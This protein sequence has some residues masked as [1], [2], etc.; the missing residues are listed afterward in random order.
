[1]RHILAATAVCLLVVVVAE[2]LAA[3]GDVTTVRITDDVAVEDTMRLGINTCGDNYWDSSIVKVRAAQNFEGL[4]YRFMSWGP[5]QDENGIFVW[6]APAEEAW[7]AMKGRV[8]WHLLGGPGKGM[9]GLIKDI[10]RKVCPADHQ[11]RELCYISFDKP[12]PASDLGKNGIMLELENFGQG[13]IRQTNNPDFWNAKQNTAQSGDVPPGSFGRSALLLRGREER[14][15]YTFVPMWGSQADQNGTWR[16]QLWAKAQA[17][18]P[19]FTIEV[20]GAENAVLEPTGE[21]QRHDLALDVAGLNSM[22]EHVEVRLVAEGGDVL[23]DDVVIWKEEDSRNPTAFRD[24][25]VDLLKRLR[26]GVL[27]HLQ[28]GG[29]NLANN[30]KPRLEQMGWTR[31]WGNL[32]KGARN[33]ARTYA[34]NMH[35]YYGLCEYVNADPWYCLPGTLHVEEIPLLMEYLG[36]PPDVGFGKVRAELG[37]PEPWTEVFDRIYIEFGNEAWNPGG[38]AT[39]SYNGPD[40]WRDMIA[41]GKASPYCTPNVVWVAGGQAG[42]SGLTGR[43]AKDWVP[44]ADMVAIA[45]YL[46]NGVRQQYMEHLT[47]D[48]AL[49]RWVFGYTIKRVLEPGGRVSSNYEAIQGTGKELSTYEHQFHLTNP[50][51]GNEGAVPM[52]TRKKMFTSLGGGLNILNDCLL[53]MREC[54]IRTQ[55]LFN[56]N[57]KGFFGI[58]LWGF[59]PGINVQDQRYRPL[60]LAEEIINKVI[61]GDMLRTEHAGARSTF[62]ARGVF[63]DSRREIGTY[64]DIPVLWSYAFRDGRRRGLVLFNL[65]TEAERPVRL[66]FPG[67]VRGDR[68]QIWWLSAD[69]IT[70]SNEYDNPEPQ[71]EIEESELPDFESGRTIVMPPHSMVGITWQAD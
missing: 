15:H 14:A 11:K 27:R 9:S 5:Q 68:A 65:D 43:I 26:P 58:P 48:D 47:T 52:E 33:S 4:L 3:E 34:F 60:F 24:P 32:V 12:V 46:M 6:F 31:R 42:S 1:M 41:A 19:A 28:M 21:W 44:N 71:V 70:A 16:I 57:Q 38:Y 40:H 7:D 63:E 69:S 55:C 37:H 67:Q 22:E 13:S 2:S 30:L 61:G 45:P 39:G 66:E 23:V 36:A 53:M 18:T 10:E 8:R 56:L 20:K 49:F 64:E 25:M 62:T 35:D 29:S 17:G 50:R 54:G 51:P 59:V